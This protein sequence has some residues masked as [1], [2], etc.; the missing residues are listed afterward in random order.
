MIDN[1]YDETNI[2][3]ELL[4]C[5]RQVTN[6]HKAF[7]NNLSANIKLWKLALSEITQSGWFFGRFVGLSQK[8]DL[9]LMKNV[10]QQL[11]TD[12]LKPVWVGGGL[13]LSSLRPDFY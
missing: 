9:P 13:Q 2:S 5:N 4:L 6:L 3:H 11:G 1:S 8:T 7:A 12:W 10:L